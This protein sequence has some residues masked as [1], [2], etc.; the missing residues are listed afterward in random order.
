M[1]DEDQLV[2]HH[3]LVPGNADGSEIWLAIAKGDMPKDTADACSIGTATDADYCGLS[4]QEKSALHHALD[5]LQAPTPQPQVVASEP[6]KPDGGSAAPNTAPTA[7]TFTTDRDIIRL[8]SDDVAQANSTDAASYRYLTLTHLKNAGDP[9]RDLQVYRSAMTKLLNSLSTVSDAFTPTAIDPAKTVYRIDLRRLGWSRA[10]WDRIV[11]AD[12]YVTLYNNSQFKALQSDLNT[13]APFI[14]ADWF[15]FTA[16]RPPLYYTILDLPRTKKELQAK[17]G[18]DSTRDFAERRVERAGFQRSG[19]SDNNRLIERHAMSTGAYWESY[20]F[21]A[22]GDRKSLFEFPLGPAGAF[23]DISDRF[24]F[25][26]D[27]GEIIFNLPNGFHAYYLTDG[28]GNRLD[29]GPTRIVRDPSQRDSAVTNGISCMGCHD[30]GI[31]LNP[32]RSRDTL[33]QVRGLA[34]KSGTLP[35]DAKEIVAEI[36]PEGDAFGRRLESD[37]K[38]YAEALAASGVSVSSNLDGVE[39]INALSKRFEDPLKMRLA[40]AEVGM[41][42][43]AFSDRLDAVGGASHDLRLR[44]EQDVVPRDQFVA[45]YASLVNAVNENGDKAVPLGTVAEQ[46]GTTPDAVAQLGKKSPQVTKTFDLA[47]VASATDLRIGDLITFTLRSEQPCFLSL[48]DTDDK[49]KVTVLFPNGFHPDSRIEAGTTVAIPGST[50]A[51]FRLRAPEA[52]TDRVTATCN[53][54]FPDLAQKQGGEKFASYDSTR[55]LI[56]AQTDQRKHYT[57]SLKVESDAEPASPTGPLIANP[58]E[59]GVPIVAQK[60]VVLNIH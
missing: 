44:L 13:N 6:G 47:F 3:K 21:G 53:T 55:S 52:G 33:D 51:G 4:E 27:G 9:E 37:A 14:H 17:L 38:H 5:A 30:K 59:P 26:Q 57:R 32:F 46:S 50:V 1:L 24:G 45:L 39:M 23:G 15:A 29:I 34:L 7:S 11:A 28:K 22:N 16:A 10:T 31:K 35:S 20:D 43:A 8:I 36:F 25:A 18:V 60:S 41:T 49:G 40:A 19:V 42:E 48:I 2:R 54:S 56:A 12:P 58:I